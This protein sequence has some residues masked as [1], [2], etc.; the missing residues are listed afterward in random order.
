MMVYGVE[1]ALCISVRASSQQDGHTRIAYRQRQSFES[2]QVGQVTLE[3][4][5]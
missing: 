1:Y 2:N 3:F 5:T 4:M